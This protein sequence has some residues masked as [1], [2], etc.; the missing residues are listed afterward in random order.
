MMKKY[1]TLYYF[2]FVVLILGAFASMAQYSYGLIICGIACLGF[3]GAFLVEAFREVTTAW[4]T[5]PSPA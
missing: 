3:T 2:L 4:A 1:N 5:C